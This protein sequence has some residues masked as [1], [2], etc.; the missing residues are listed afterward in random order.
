MVAFATLALLFTIMRM[1]NPPTTFV[2]ADVTISIRPGA[3]VAAAAAI[4]AIVFALVAMRERR[5]ARA[6]PRTA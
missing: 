5:A 3:F 1:A 6:E 2:K 4:A